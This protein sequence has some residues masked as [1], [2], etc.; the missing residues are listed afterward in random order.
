LFVTIPRFRITLV[1]LKIRFKLA[2][3]SFSKQQIQ[4]FRRKLL[5]FVCNDSPFQDHVSNPEDK[6]QV[7]LKIFFEA[8]NPKLS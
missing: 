6:I 3:K 5:G 7:C 1:I 4:S 2:W 8:K